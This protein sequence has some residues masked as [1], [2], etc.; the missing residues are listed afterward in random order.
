MVELGPLKIAQHHLTQVA[1]VTACFYDY[2]VNSL[3]K[4]FTKAF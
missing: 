2:N 1:F 4:L 3:A